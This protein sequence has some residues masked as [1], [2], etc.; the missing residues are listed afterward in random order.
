MTQ[1]GTTGA[2]TASEG[3]SRAAR[4]RSVLRA[5]FAAARPVVV[6]GAHDA[7]TARLIEQRAFDGVWVSGLGVSTAQL[8]VPDLN[9]MTFTE[10]LEAAVRIDR[11]TELPVIADCDN[12]YGGMLNVLR[13]AREYELAGIAGICLEDNVFPKRNSLLGSEVDRELLP[14]AEHAR[15]IAAIKGRQDGPDFVVIARVEALIAGLGVD[16]AIDRALAY[17]AAGADAIVIHSRDK[18]LAEIDTFLERWRSVDPGVPLVAIPTLFPTFSAEELAARGFAMV[19]F[20]NQP[21]RG[22]VRAMEQVLDALRDE[23]RAA[24]ADR[25]VDPVD[26]VFDL[27]ETRDAIALDDAG[28]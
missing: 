2:S 22:A 13:T 20:A 1:D 7:L 16:E 28:S 12:G 15:R 4:K 24:A 23:R 10:A 19:I 8:G 14:K 25:F 18:T 3:M 26:H 27:V 9:L 6:V 17:A 21:L 11:A 5:G